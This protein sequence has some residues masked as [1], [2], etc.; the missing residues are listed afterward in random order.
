[1]SDGRP[2]LTGI[3]HSLPS[4]RLM[5]RQYRSW[6]SRVVHIGL[7][8]SCRDEKPPLAERSGSFSMG[9]WPY[10]AKDGSYF[11]KWAIARL[12]EHDTAGDHHGNFC[13]GTSGAGNR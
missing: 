7:T 3:G 2:A 9:A 11:V 5:A 8:F 4:R 12:S 10:P 13:S 1:M 6:V